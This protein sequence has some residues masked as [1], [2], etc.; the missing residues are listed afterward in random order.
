MLRNDAYLAFAY[1]PDGGV[2]QRLC[3]YK[4]L[5]TDSGFDV[6]AT[7]AAVAYG[8]GMYLK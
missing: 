7:A 1:D 4:P 8:V 5:R 3:M 6:G 2:S